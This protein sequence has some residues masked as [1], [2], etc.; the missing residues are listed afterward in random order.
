M[1]RTFIRKE[2][3]HFSYVKGGCFGVPEKKGCNLFDLRYADQND[4]R[5]GMTKDGRPIQFNLAKSGLIPSIRVV[6][7]E[8]LS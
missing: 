4:G 7:L 1:K 3:G 8:K 2:K 6:G 5:F